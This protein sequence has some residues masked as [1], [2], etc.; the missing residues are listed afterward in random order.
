VA[1]PL[2]LLTPAQFEDHVEHWRTVGPGSYRQPC[3][4]AVHHPRPLPSG[5][6]PRHPAGACSLGGCGWCLE[7]RSGLLTRRHY[8]RR[9]GAVS[10]V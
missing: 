10:T 3:G 9:N 4:L 8:C 6:T 2:P 1:L 5:V 7:Y